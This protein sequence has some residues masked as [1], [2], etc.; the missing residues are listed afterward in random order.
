MSDAPT[1]NEQRL[2]ITAAAHTVVVKVGTRVLTLSDGTLN[3]PRIE[4]L[5]EEIHAVAA[6]GRKVVL[7]SSGAVGAGMSL[8]KLTS[9]PS[10]LV[11]RADAR[12][13]VGMHVEAGLRHVK[14]EQLAVGLAEDRL[15]EFFLHDGAF[16]FEIRVV[17]IQI[18]HPVGFRPEQSF[19]II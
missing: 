3:Y 6:A 15:A 16:G 14:A 17:N 5:A 18:D 13:P 11:H 1:T 8:L 7:V 4:R 9:R 2:A 12:A 10:D 19:Q